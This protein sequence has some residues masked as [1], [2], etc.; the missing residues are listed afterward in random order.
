MDKIE[1]ILNLL[2]RI[3]EENVPLVVEGK[4]DVDALRYIGIKGDIKPLNGKPL[5]EFAEEISKEFSEVIILTDFDKEGKNLKKMLIFYFEKNGVKTNT[6]YWKKL[7]TLSKSTT[8][9]GLKNIKKE[10]LTWVL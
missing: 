3:K 10:V 4:K 2:R 6:E 8:I 5:Y 9:E 7:S 1:E